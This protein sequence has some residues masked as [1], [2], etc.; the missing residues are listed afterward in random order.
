MTVHPVSREEFLATFK[1]GE[2]F[3]Y[4]GSLFWKPL[5]ATGPHTITYI[6]PDDEFHSE[7]TIVR[8]RYRYGTLDWEYLKE[9]TGNSP[10]GVFRTEDDAKTYIREFCESLEETPD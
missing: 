10:H 5:Q 1:V 2:E 6:G 9:L 3:W 8:Y 4:V 7:A